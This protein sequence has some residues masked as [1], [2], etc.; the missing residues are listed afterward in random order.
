MRIL[1][2][3]LLTLFVSGWVQFSSSAIYAQDFKS[4]YGIEQ[5]AMNSLGYREIAR[6][7]GYP[8]DR[9][10]MP[11]PYSSEQLV[12]F[13]MRDQEYNP[14]LASYNFKND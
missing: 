13:A 6:T 11:E 14:N 10:A 5:K 1:Q 2:L 8:V 7:D 9:Y 12:T 3:L 4:A